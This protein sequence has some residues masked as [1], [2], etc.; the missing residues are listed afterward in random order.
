LQYAQIFARREDLQKEVERRLAAGFVRWV[1]RSR[2]QAGVPFGLRLRRAAPLRQFPFYIRRFLAQFGGTM[3]RCLSRLL[4]VALAGLLAG[5]IPSRAAATDTALA[6]FAVLEGN[7]A[8]LQVGRVGKTLADE[9]RAAQTT[10]AVSN[11]IAGTVLDLRFAGGDDLDSA[12]AAADWFAAKKPLV[13]ILVNAET[14]GAAAKLAEDLRGERAGLIFG[15]STEVKPDIAVAVPIE[16]EKKYL[17]NPFAT[18]TAD[19]TDS[20]GAT[21]NLL[22]YVDHTTEADLVRA[23][24]RSGG[25]DES[26]QAASAAEPPKPFIHDPVLARGVDFIRGLAALHPI[27]N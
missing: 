19:A 18:T 20:P 7:V 25:A 10:L 27:Q 16:D 21:T 3:T 17:E 11:R 1:A 14:R 15:S 6:K 26:P 12:K 4:V 2:L 8:Y 23:S 5:Q 22:P 9:I 24:L 13:A